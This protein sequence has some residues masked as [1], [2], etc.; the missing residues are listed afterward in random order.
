[1]ANL[2]NFTI[3]SVSRRAAPDGTPLEVQVTCYGIQPS[4]PAEGA[5]DENPFF[6][7]ATNS[8]LVLQLRKE[9]VEALGLNEGVVLQIVKG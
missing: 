6:G 8:V 3:T 7:R 1:M 9:Q 4:K 2:L 5:K